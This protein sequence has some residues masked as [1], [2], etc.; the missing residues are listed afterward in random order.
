MVALHSLI[1]VLGTLLRA[2]T[3]NELAETKRD[4]KTRAPRSCKVLESGWV[5]RAQGF[6]GEPVPPLVREFMHVAL[7][8]DAWYTSKAGLPRNHET[9]IPVAHDQPVLAVQHRCVIGLRLDSE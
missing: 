9:V 8:E 3:R 5:V 7:D 6:Y 4:L 2:H 1:L